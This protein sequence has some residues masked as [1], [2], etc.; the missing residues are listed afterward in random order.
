MALCFLY[1]LYTTDAEI[2]APSGQIWKL[3]RERYIQ[4]VIIP[5]P[6]AQGWNK[7]MLCCFI[8]EGMYGQNQ[9]TIIFFK[10]H[11]ELTGLR[12]QLVFKLVLISTKT[13]LHKNRLQNYLI[14]IY[15]FDIWVVSQI[16]SEK[17]SYI[18]SCNCVL[19]RYFFNILIIAIILMFYNRIISRKRRC[20]KMYR[21]FLQK[22]LIPKW[23]YIHIKQSN[24]KNNIFQSQKA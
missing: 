17:Y 21:M 9:N 15:D 3:A 4:C 6:S 18:F 20:V 16:I 11:A 22:Y 14:R 24:S 12:L 8:F 2:E 23:L 19:M 13:F 1:A 5:T 7:I 10:I